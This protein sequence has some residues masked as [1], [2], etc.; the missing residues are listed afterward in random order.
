MPEKLRPFP[1]AIN[2]YIEYLKQNTLR[3]AMHHYTTC[4]A[5]LS[6][7]CEGRLWFTERKYLNDPKEI[8]QG[9]EIAKELLTKRGAHARPMPSK[10]CSMENFPNSPCSAPASAD[11]ATIPINGSVMEATIA[12][13]CSP[14]KPASS[15]SPSPTYVL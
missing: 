9:V 5:A 11:A 7:L 6:I 15:M 2:R 13:R 12:E 10:L 1:P 8:V 3:T 4:D 14:S